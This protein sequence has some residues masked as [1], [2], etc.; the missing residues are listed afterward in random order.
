MPEYAVEKI[1]VL[2][3]KYTNVE[4]KKLLENPILAKNKNEKL[5][6]QS[7]QEILLHEKM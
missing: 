3:K 2:N 5:Y 7:M 1:R 6:M 4:T